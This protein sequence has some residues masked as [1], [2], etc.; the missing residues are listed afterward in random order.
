MS[1]ET[2][3]KNE[4]SNIRKRS[5]TCKVGLASHSSV[6]SSPRAEVVPTPVVTVSCASSECASVINTQYS[7]IPSARCRFPVLVCPIQSVDCGCVLRDPQNTF[8]RITRETI[9]SGQIHHGAL[10][11]DDQIHALH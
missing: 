2:E 6:K 11:V 1:F 10:S 8:L 5:P 7:S 4:E 9:P 3:G